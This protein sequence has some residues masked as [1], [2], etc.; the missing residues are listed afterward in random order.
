MIDFE[1]LLA[2]MTL[3]EK[4]SMLAGKDLWHT[5][6]VPR[7]NIPSIQVTDGP[8]GVRG[9]WSNLGPAS[10]CL[11]VGTA[12]GATWNSELV[13]RLGRLL[14]D[15]VKVKNAHILLAPTVNIHRTPI[16]GRNF[17]CF[18]ED[19]YLS[20]QM[21]SA[22]IKGIQSN[23]VG[24]CIKHFVCNDQEFERT[25]ISSEVAERPLHEIYLEPFRLALRDAR[26][27][28]VM[29]AYNKV[30]GAF[31]SENDDIL[32]TILKEGWGFDG[33]VMSDWFGTYTPDV[34]AGG[35]ELEMPGPARWMSAEHVKKALECGELTPAALDDKVRRIL[36]TAE[37]VGAY[38]HP[39]PEEERTAD[40]PEQRR[41][42]REAARESIV[43]LANRQIL[44]LA[45]EKVRHIAVIGDLAHWPN[46]MGGGSS[47]VTPYYVVSPLDGIRSRAGDAI[48]VEYAPG[49]FVHQ[50][51]PA[52]AADSLA[53]A[54][55][56]CGLDLAIYDNLDFSGQPAFTQVT[57]RSK[58]GWFD[59]SVP[60][61][62]QE[63][64]SAR[65]TGFFTPEESGVHTFGLNSVG[66]SRL[67][68]DGNVVLDNWSD[69]PVY[70]E[71]TIQIP[72]TAG[73]PYAL[74]LEYRWQGDPRWRS[75]NLGHRPPHAADLMAEAVTLAEQA[76]VVILVAGLTSE[77]ESEGFDRVDMNLPG[78]Q[79]ELIERVAAAN[80]NTIVVL[81][82]GSAVA[83]PWVDGV[84]A[85]VAQWYNSQ[86][87][88][89]ALADVLFGD[90]S[91]S[92]KLPTTFPRR[93]EDNPAYSNYPG[94]NGKV[95]YGE[96]LFVGYR[97]YDKEELEPL[98]PFGHGLS[99]TSFEYSGLWLG[100]QQFTAEA[101]LEVRFDVRNA[102]SRP[103][104]EIVQLYVRDPQSALVRPVQEL[105]VFTKVAL[106]PGETRCVTFHLDRE[107]FWYYDPAQG[108][109]RVEPG[110]FEILVG[111]SS[112]DLRLRGTALLVVSDKVT[113]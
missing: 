84:A 41:L 30:N 95:F 85:V 9:A 72:M 39:E 40:S 86:E 75:V 78:A 48:K 64:F 96:G 98:F 77:W 71:K 92:G 44:P 91:P 37:R 69:T 57:R 101:G 6:P 107:A 62:N 49:C 14:A 66:Q 103:G 38:A 20:G 73:Q 27:W 79:D 31:A 47:Q 17:E 110:E 23:G 13:E 88:G 112:R 3:D 109:W 24:A 54:A 82:A 51:L 28:T 34:A 68:I 90:V 25:S 67:A 1:K 21:A 113:R 87:C 65:L 2:E 80:P 45:T 108:G 53:T 4:I 50:T 63:R 111:A 56:S 33:L 42:I 10:A 100:E 94:E 102:G 59:N 70:G 60:N 12:L 19:P 52:L 61:V 99:Y 97:H 55:G 106:A 36:R 89:N 104:K 11:P 83:M 43:L 8:N 22:Y 32:K 46:I 105:K 58:F 29:A 81:N 16:A 93:L 7:L 35:L 74:E 76:D 5:V 18:S 15:E 26:P